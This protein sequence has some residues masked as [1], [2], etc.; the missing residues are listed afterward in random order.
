[1]KVY[2]DNAA[3]TAVDKAVIDEM[4]PFFTEE[5]A[6][7]AGS[8]SFSSGARNAVALSRSRVAQLIGAE[9]SEVFF[10]SGGTESDNMALVGVARSEA[11]VGNRRNRIIT[12]QIEHPAVLN[13][14][15]ALE[16]EGFD[17]RYAPVDI[18]GFVDTGFI[19]RYADERTALISI[20]TANNELGTIQD[21]GEISRI[22]HDCGALFHTDAVQA[23]GHIPIR[24][25]GNGSNDIDLLSISG[26]KLHGPK[27]IG[28]LYVRRGIRPYIMINGGGQEKGLR[29]GTLNVP[30]IVG[31]GKAC[32]IALHSL[33]IDGAGDGEEVHDSAE[34]IDSMYGK[35]NRFIDMIRS[36]IDG[37]YFNGPKDRVLPSIVHV[38]FTGI[39]CERNMLFDRI[40]MQCVLR[41]TFACS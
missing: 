28:A 31:L 13:T 30:G 5:Y 35:R 16:A 29:S 22:A 10:T 24:V 27:G 25:N 12:S 11:A 19:R 4:L 1:M 18:Q 34:R 3:S 14:A 32:E 21:I 17:V 15:R 2:L 33:N 9:P 23:A 7:P 8:C 40:R 39:E 20:M 36:R 41:Q 6:N 37:V 38:S 26:H